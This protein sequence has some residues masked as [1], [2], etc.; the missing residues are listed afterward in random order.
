MCKQQWY[1]LHITTQIFVIILLLLLL[2]SVSVIIFTMYYYFILIPELLQKP[3]KQQPLHLMDQFYTT[4]NEYY[5]YTLY[6]QILMHLEVH[7]SFVYALL[8]FSR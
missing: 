7:L 3:I 1:Y 8:M 5:I 2:S 6:A 4:S